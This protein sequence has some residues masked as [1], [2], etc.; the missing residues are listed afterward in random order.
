MDKSW[1]AD[2]VIQLYAAVH[3]LTGY[4][5]PEQMPVVRLLP[6]TEIQ[7]MVCSGP[8]QIR[9]FYHPDFGVILDETFNLKSSSYHQSILLHELV[10]H[11]QHV[12]GKFDNLRSACHARS[13]SE[14]EAYEVQNLYLAKHSGSERIPV[15]RWSL[16]CDQEEAE[17]LRP[18]SGSRSHS[19]L[20]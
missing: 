13:A 20:E 1:L 3:T 4:P 12:T 9:A 11:A 15:L 7:N 16:L 10:H 6:Q 19:T 17:S 8:C 18:P 2:L 5:A 14:K